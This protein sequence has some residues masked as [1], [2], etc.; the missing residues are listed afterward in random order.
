[1]ETAADILHEQLPATTKEASTS[2]DEDQ[3]VAE[4]RERVSKLEQ[5]VRETDSAKNLSKVMIQWFHFILG[6][7]SSL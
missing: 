7:Q 3:E 5:I 6:F 1:M 2:T 4:L